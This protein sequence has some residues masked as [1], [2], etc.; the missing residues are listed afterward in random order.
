MGTLDNR[1]AL[2]TGG[3]SGIGEAITRALAAEGCAITLAGRRTAAIDAVA[4]SLP[5]A[6]AVQA[7]ITDAAQC[8][9]LASAA[10]DAFG[11]L[12]IVIANAGAAESAPFSR[13]TPA[14]WQRMLDVN[15]TG[16]FN[17]AYACLSDL[18]RAEAADQKPLRR[19]IFIASTA[20][21]K[22]YPYVSAYVAA[23]HGLVGLTRALAL[24]FSRTPLTV[25]AICP[26]FTE[27]PLLDASIS[28][29]STKTGRATSD[30]A[31]DLAKGNPQ[32]RFITPGEVAATALWLTSDAARSITGQALS[33]SGGET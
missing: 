14:L 1:H 3:G 21:L 28:T 32:N 16:A 27:T 15:L 8:A 13:T 2:I 30:A 4:V 24:E 18:T 5:K 33:I 31:A 11:P 7:D 25:N 22:G 10:R 23:K 29:I 9:R 6:R 19:L 20:G 26:G 17:T 12:D